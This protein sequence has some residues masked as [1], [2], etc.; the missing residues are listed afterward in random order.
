M[1]VQARAA[2]SAVGPLGGWSLT[3]LPT[4]HGITGWVVAVEP[5]DGPAHR[6][7]ASS[8]QTRGRPQASLS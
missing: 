3:T 7:P 4:G 2:D 6:T 5:E 1:P 8:D